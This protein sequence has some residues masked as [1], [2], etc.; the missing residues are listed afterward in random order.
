MTALPPLATIEALEA[1]L[2]RGALVEP[3]RAQAVAALA[4]ASGIVRDVTGRT[5]IDDLGEVVAPAIVV[6]ITLKAA[7][8]EVRNPEGNVADTAGPFS[9]RLADDQ[10]KGV[11]LLE[12][13][14]TALAK[15]RSANPGLW[16]QPTTR[17][18]DRL[19]P[20][21]LNDQYGCDPILWL[22]PP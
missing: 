7:L 15:Y 9:R 10:A 3:Q 19:Q 2:G 8:R 13:E 14:R 1:R 16:T 11:Y 5:W 22:D 4:D 20:V 6:T 17:V 21:F 12:D 18:D